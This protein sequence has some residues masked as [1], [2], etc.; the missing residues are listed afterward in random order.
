MIPLETKGMIRYCH[1]PT[2]HVGLYR[3]SRDP[4]RTRQ[5]YIEA[6]KRRNLVYF[7]SMLRT[8]TSKFQAYRLIRRLWIKAIRIILLDTS[9]YLVPIIIDYLCEDRIKP[10]PTYFTKY[11]EINIQYDTLNTPIRFSQMAGRL[12]TLGY[13]W[14]DIPEVDYEYESYLSNFE[15]HHHLMVT[16]L[17]QQ[18]CQ[19]KIR[20]KWPIILSRL[21]FHLHYDIYNW[22]H[23]V[24]SNRL[25]LTLQAFHRKHLLSLE[26]HSLMT[27]W[28]ERMKY[29]SH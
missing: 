10:I 15:S 24:L 21:P 12:V 3:Q 23:N 20:Y 22:E 26:E 28:I 27:S 14:R 29:P 5:Y 2:P 8:M 9:P 7:P 13:P 17:Y 4:Y 11:Y 16:D 19:K 1:P 6:K 25:T 18:L